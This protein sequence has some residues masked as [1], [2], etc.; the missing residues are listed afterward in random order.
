LSGAVSLEQQWP[1]SGCRD[2]GG[3]N[4]HNFVI[5]CLNEASEVFI[6]I[7]VKRR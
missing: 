5:T 3:L 4:R 6:D 7:Y 1:G 2:C